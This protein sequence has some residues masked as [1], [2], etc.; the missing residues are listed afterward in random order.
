MLVEKSYSSDEGDSFLS[1]PR[2]QPTGWDLGVLVG[3]RTLGSGMSRTTPNSRYQEQVLRSL[4]VIE[5]LKALSCLSNV[6]AQS[7]ALL[8]TAALPQCSRPL[9]NTPGYHSC[10]CRS[11]ISNFGTWSTPGTIL[12]SFLFA[13][14]NLPK[15]K[16]PREIPIPESTPHPASS[17]CPNNPTHVSLPDPPLSCIFR[18]PPPWP[19]PCSR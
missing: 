3:W 18:K 13:P 12:R 9:K 5:Q 14:S 16:R 17:Q 1:Y 19:G 7:C 15:P 11:A 8:D 2:L 6:E 4:A 10:Q